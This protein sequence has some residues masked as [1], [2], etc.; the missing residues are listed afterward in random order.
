MAYAYPNNE[1]DLTT[2]LLSVNWKPL[3]G[4]DIGSRSVAGVGSVGVAGLTT[5]VPVMP[6]IYQ[7]LSR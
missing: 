3:P 1:D 2:R 6:R 4:T 5:I 7:L